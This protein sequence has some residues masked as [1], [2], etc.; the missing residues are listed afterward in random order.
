MPSN[1][2]DNLLSSL[3]GLKTLFAPADAI[4]KERLLR[5]LDKRRITDSSS[6]IRFHE[7]LL[8]MRAYPQNARL[9]RLTERLLTSFA[10]RVDQLRR[11]GTDL[12]DLNYIEVS[13][14]A[15]TT[16][17]GTFSYDIARWLARR[18][19][20]ALR[21]DWDE[22]KTKERLATVL[23]G[24]IPLLHEDSLVE[25]NVPYLTWLRDV[26]GGAGRD[27]QW[28]LRR[29]E[30]S[31]SSA[32]QKGAIYDSLELP[33]A[34]DLGN[35]RA[36]RTRARVQTG[37]TFYHNTPLIRRNE[38]SLP[39][40]LASPPPDLE[41]LSRPDGQAM[42]DVL[43]EATT[44]RYRELYGITHG[45]PDQVV[46]CSIGRGVEICLWGLPAERR[47][48]LR[49]Y[50]AGFTVKNGVPINYIEAICLFERAEVG[51]NQFYTFRD[52]ESAWIYARVLRLLKQALGVTAISID[53]Y[54]I[55]FGNDEAIESGAFWFY[56]KLGFR[57][58]RPELR[59]LAESEEGKIKAKPGYRSRGRVLRRLS[60]G[61]MIYEG[62][63]DRKPGLPP[64]PARS[65]DWDDFQV[66]NIGLAV[67]HRMATRFSGDPDKMRSASMVKLSRMLNI[68][69]AK[70][71]N[72][73]LED[74]SLVLALIPDLARWLAPEKRALVAIVRAK[75]GAPEWRYLRLLQR[76]VRLRAALI[77]IGSSRKGGK[78]GSTKA[79]RTPR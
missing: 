76:H 62:A 4:R 11:A 9:L 12:I 34:W 52:G 43:R 33:I 1:S 71:N 70:W 75:S 3:E 77:E 39:E 53:P 2:I 74:L 54:Q 23:P 79:Q 5:S 28:L 25:A 40:V 32:R 50:A 67:A 64:L 68:S 42:I 29:F 48:P 57:P 66:R 78:P 38:V 46:K 21:I 61:H 56:R 31:D 6:L 41:K 69:S 51:F 26:E 58:T 60:A 7:A 59:A 35:S 72:N 24:F 49:A 8:F 63:W 15:G 30:A 10:G 47:L 16:I 20:R 37:R 45:D 44:V 55:G 13:G 36:S 18:Y 14:I 27:L 65:G 19:P 22:Y 73:A 17:T